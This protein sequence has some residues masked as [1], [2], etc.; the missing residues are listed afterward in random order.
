MPVAT[1]KG[2]VL[3]GGN[4]TLSEQ[5][6]TAGMEHYTSLTVLGVI[7]LCLTRTLATQ[8]CTI[9]HNHTTERGG[10]EDM[11]ISKVHCRPHSMQV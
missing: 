2:A 8:Y 3:F 7:H 9:I 1:L 4:D 10:E 6:H 11:P 5:P